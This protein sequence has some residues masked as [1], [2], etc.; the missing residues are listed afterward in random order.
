MTEFSALSDAERV[1]RLE[2]PQLAAGQV[3]MVLDTD[4]Y[5][6]IDDQFALAY[7][8]LSPERIRLEAV[9]AAPF[10]NPLLSG[11]AE[12][13]RLSYEE[14]LRVLERVG[15]THEGFVFEGSS[16]WLPGHATAV[17]SPA[18]DDLITRAAARDGERPLYVV[19][20]GAPTNVS[21]ALLKA[22]EIAEKI[23]VVWLG[24]NPSYWHPGAEYNVYQDMRASRV[25]LDCGVPLVH[26]P[27]VNVTEKLKTTLPEIDRHVRPYGTLGA[28]LAEIYE[29]H[30]DD[31]F[32]RSKEIWDVG[33]IAWLV[34]PDWAPSVLVPSPVLNDNHAWSHDPSRHLVREIRDLDRDAIFRDLFRKLWAAAT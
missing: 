15:R 4:T 20:I 25:L 32:G 33:A 13:M 11:P 30:S 2:E 6:E 27:C 1:R 23:V 29:A 17:D 16:S 18:A 24:G 14:I 34:N 5:N 28:Y 8:L 22:P 10:A 31:H 26:V 12:G 7:A 9:Y 3:D 19:A 21:S